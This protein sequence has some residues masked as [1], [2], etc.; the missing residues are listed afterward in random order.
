VASEIEEVRRSAL[1]ALEGERF[2]AVELVGGSDVAQVIDSLHRK[3]DWA[4]LSKI[5]HVREVPVDKRHNAKVD[6]VALAKI[7]GHD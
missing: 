6:Y 1:Y 5:H 7:V 4:Q 2:L 3:L